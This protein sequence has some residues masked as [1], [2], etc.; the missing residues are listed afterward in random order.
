VSYR[1]ILP[2]TDKVS[3]RI[4]GIFL[5]YDFIILTMVRTKRSLV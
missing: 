2:L 4:P 5:S 1:T 3:N